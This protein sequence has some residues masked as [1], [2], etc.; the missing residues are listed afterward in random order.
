MNDIH[1]YTFEIQSPDTGFYKQIWRVN[2]IERIVEKKFLLWKF[3]EEE[4][5]EEASRLAVKNKVLELMEL[6]PNSRI[7]VLQWYND[8]DGLAWHPNVIWENGGW[9]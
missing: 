3:Q 2:P 8:D 4:L 7:R 9:I 1:K 5:D 6:H